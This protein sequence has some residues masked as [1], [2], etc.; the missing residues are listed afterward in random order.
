MLEGSSL[1]FSK[2][3]EQSGRKILGE[4]KEITEYIIW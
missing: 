1:D 3:I 2:K 4:Y